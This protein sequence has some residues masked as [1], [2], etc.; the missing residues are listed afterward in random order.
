[1][2]DTDLKQL[3]YEIVKKLIMDKKISKID[4]T[5]YGSTCLAIFFDD[6]VLITPITDMLTYGR[7]TFPTE[8]GKSRLENNTYL[9]YYNSDKLYLDIE[10]VNT[11]I[12]KISDY[13]A[14]QK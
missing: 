4:N 2:S 6:T 1:M 3:N 9:H 5:S 14:N 12:D 10:L 8:L 7:I 13:V 11:L